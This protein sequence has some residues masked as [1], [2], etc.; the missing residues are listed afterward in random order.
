MV[1]FG[2]RASRIKDG[3]I[4]N[5][6]C[7]SCETQTSMAYAIFGKYAHI[8]WIPTFPVGKENV[9]ECDHCK[10]TFTLKELPEQIKHKFNLE[11]QG[12]GFPIWY[13]SGIAIIASIIAIGAYVSKQD[14]ADDINY[15]NS[16]QIGDVYSIDNGENSY[17]AMKV[18]EVTADS[19]YVLLN[20]YEIDKKNA[21]DEIDKTEYYTTEKYSFSSKDILNMFNEETIFEVDRD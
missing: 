13:F 18:Y 4:N 3:R 19:V 12:S 16:P 14:D 7:P 1:F 8:Y 9:L 21:I 15:I 17:S 5:V 2:S 20:D 6:T 11:K 10:K